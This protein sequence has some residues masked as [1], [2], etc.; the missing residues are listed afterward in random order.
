MGQQQ[1]FLIDF[2]NKL[3]Y[4]GTTPQ[5]LN[6]PCNAGV[7]CRFRYPAKTVAGRAGGAAGSRYLAKHAC[8]VTP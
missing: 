1:S 4:I 8:G 3:C 5:L 2:L 6:M 7:F